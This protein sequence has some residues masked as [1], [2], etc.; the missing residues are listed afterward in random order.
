M[1]A[2]GDHL[3]FLSQPGLGR[4]SKP[5]Y[6]DISYNEYNLVVNGDSLDTSSDFYVVPYSPQRNFSTSDYLDFPD[7]S[8]TISCELS[9]YDVLRSQEQASTDHDTR[10]IEPIELNNQISSLH[11]P[12]DNFLTEYLNPEPGD[13]VWNLVC[14]GPNSQDYASTI[15]N[16]SSSGLN[17]EF[18]WNNPV[19]PADMLFPITF[20]TGIHSSALP[21]TEYPP[22]QLSDSIASS[23]LYRSIADTSPR[24][25][26]RSSRLPSLEPCQPHKRL[27]PSTEHPCRWATCLEVFDQASKLR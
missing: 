14:P 20:W 18:D 1:W 2:H 11:T 25:I 6:C 12:E 23:G 27:I 19:K 4:A 24:K 5:G 7:L 17:T 13:L 10:T 3:V 22:A 15:G 9:Q 21:E 26:P 8:S 16:P